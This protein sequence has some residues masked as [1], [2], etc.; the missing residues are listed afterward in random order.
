[1]INPA[2]CETIRGEI[3]ISGRDTRYP[4]EAYCFILE[5]LEYFRLKTGEKRHVTGQELSMALLDFCIK[6]FGPMANTVFE[7]W[8]ISSTRDFGYLVYNLIDIQ[9]LQKQPQDTLEDFF[10]PIDISDYLSQQEYFTL[11]KQLIKK[12]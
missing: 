9:I 4:V 1:M 2:V 3:I 12:V 11:E 7:R 6:Q 10:M 8:S 5:G